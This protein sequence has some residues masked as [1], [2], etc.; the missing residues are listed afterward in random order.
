MSLSRQ[1][2]SRIISVS[3]LVPGL[4]AEVV[5]YGTVNIV[6][7]LVRVI[8]RYLSSVEFA[9][10]SFQSYTLVGVVEADDNRLRTF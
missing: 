10:E 8:V 5:P 3:R 1:Y 6:K 2:L 9:V 7:K 4:P